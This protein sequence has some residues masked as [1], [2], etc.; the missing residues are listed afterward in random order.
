MISSCTDANGPSVTMGV[1]VYKKGL[2]EALKRGLK[3]RLITEINESNLKY[4]KE[5]A[6]ISE[7]RHLEGIRS[8]FSVSESEYIG[9]ASLQDATPVTQII[10][11]NLK[12]IVDQQQYMFEALW[13]KAVPS[14]QPIKQIEQSLPVEKTEVIYGG[15]SC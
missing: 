15:T 7:L 14:L 6:K 12:A 4:C 1:E 3:L 8:N 9:S 2:D 10:Y 13:S 5:L 11:S